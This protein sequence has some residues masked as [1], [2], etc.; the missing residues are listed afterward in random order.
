M[1]TSYAYYLVES[2]GF[3]FE[4]IRG[5]INVHYN[6]V[7]RLKIHLTYKEDTQM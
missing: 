2:V 3:G 4:L 6:S 5:I 1:A 7:Q